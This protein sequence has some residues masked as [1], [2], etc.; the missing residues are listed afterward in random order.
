MMTESLRERFSGLFPGSPKKPTVTEVMPNRSWA[1]ISTRDFGQLLFAALVPNSARPFYT[2]EA[3]CLFLS[4]KFHAS[5]N[6]KEKKKLFSFVLSSS[7]PMLK[8]SFRPQLKEVCLRV[9]S[10]S[11]A[12]FPRLLTSVV[13]VLQ[14][15][16]KLIR[17]SFH[18]ACVID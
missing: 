3:L 9:T 7:S 5:E 13:V 11:P 4:S 14:S 10:T 6:P 8:Q 2:I 15:I 18:V 16:S 17:R 1:F 12:L